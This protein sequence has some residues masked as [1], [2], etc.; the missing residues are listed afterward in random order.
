MIGTLVN[1]GAVIVGGAV[2][3]MFNK[4]MPERFKTIYFQAVGLFY[5]GNG[6]WYGLQ[7]AKHSD[8]GEQRGCGSTFRR[9]D[10]Y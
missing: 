8:S 10:E 5:N 6:N 3:M 1:A 9:M 4:S 2:G 7:Y